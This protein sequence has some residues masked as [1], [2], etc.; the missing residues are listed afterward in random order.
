MGIFHNLSIGQKLNIGFGILVFLLLLIVSLIFAAG[1]DATEN[2]NLTVDVRVPAALASTRAQTNL[3]KMR[4]AVRGYLAVGDLNNIDDYNRAKELF[5]ENLAQL[6]SLSE[7]WSDEDDV[8]RLDELITTFAS[9]LPLPE[10]LF[11]LHDNPLENQPALQLATAQIQPMSQF[12]MADIDRLI[13][14]QGERSSSPENRRLLATMIDI[15]ASLQAMSTNLRAYAG[16]G[17]LSFKFGY[18]DQLVIN[19]RRFG[20]LDDAQSTLTG[21]QQLL[22]S[23]F[24]HQRDDFLSL[25]AQLFAAVEGAR[26]HEDLYL[27]QHEMEPQAEQMLQLLETLTTGQQLRLQ[28]ELTDGAQRLAGV[29]Y[30]TLL[31]GLLALLLGV[32]MAYFFRESIAGPIRRLNTAAQR[33]GAGSLSVQARVEHSDEIGRLAATFNN[34]ADRIRTM[35]DE[36]GHARD[37]AETANR[38]KSDFLARMSHELRTPLNGIL[39][40]VQILARHP[41]LDEAQRHALTVIQG[42]GEHLLTLIT[43]ILDLSKIE[44]RKLELTPTVFPLAQFLD[45]IV[46][47]FRIRAEEQPAIE[48]HFSATTM[49]P[50]T[51]YADEKRVRQVLLNLLDNAFKFTTAGEITLQVAVEQLGTDAKQSVIEKSGEKV[52]MAESTSGNR[53]KAQ[54]IFTLTD[55][56]VGIPE[57]QIETIFLP[58]EQAGDRR[59][60][61]QGTGL[62]LA[63]S[64]ELAR[65]MQGDLTVSSVVGEGSQFVFTLVTS[66]AYNNNEAETA[67]HTSRGSTLQHSATGPLPPLPR[68]QSAKLHPLPTP[69]SPE[70]LAILL[71]MAHKGELPRLRSHVL[72]LSASSATYKPFVDA[73]T[74]LADQYEEEALLR[75]LQQYE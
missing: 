63:I 39:G 5:Q 17:D 7:D 4:A 27:F 14:L 73:V 38:A 54:I 11:L 60:R 72:T 20:E 75:L 16:T 18:A 37:I 22:F 46:D 71:D 30:Q 41:A 24:S 62:G 47:V 15:Q 1:R 64:H 26:S 34:M 67:L 52:Q 45:G 50:N 32:T 43:D 61:M 10:R 44:A 31:G 23:Q 65:A 51:I 6:K 28:R 8:R 59:Q 68:G 13:A 21:E 55:S 9:W 35:I 40:Y 58:F 70:E 48:F 12:L 66:V 33:L 25:P 2:I 42:N 56:G 53:Q 57:T 3:L 74:A 36:L 49:L 69:P 19:S 29:Q